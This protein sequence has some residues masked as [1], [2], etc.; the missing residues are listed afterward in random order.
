M[1]KAILEKDV[2]VLRGLIAGLESELSTMQERTKEREERV[3]SIYSSLEAISLKAEILQEINEMLGLDLDIDDLLSLIMDSVLR[4]MRTD[5]GSILLLDKS[6]TKLIFKVAKGPMADEVKKFDVP[7]GE[8]IAGWVAKEGQPLIVPNP[9]EDKRFKRDIAEEIGYL[10][11]NLLCVPL[12]A[13]RKVIGVIEVINTLGKEAFTKDDE[14]LLVSI[15]NQV[16]VLI[17]NAS[18]FHDLVRKVSEKTVLTEVARTVN[19]SLNIDRVLEISMKL[20]SQLMRSEASS[21]MLL[22][23]SKNELIFKVALGKKGESVKEIRI[24]L[25]V[26]IA[27][28]VAEKGEPLIVPDCSKDPMFFKDAD[29]KSGFKTRSILCVP[30]R[31]KDRTIGVAE[32]INKIG[33]TFVDEDI[34]LFEAIALQIAIALENASLYKDLEDLFISTVTSLAATI[35]AK[36]PYTHGHSQ[37]VCEYSFAIGKEMGLLEDEIKEL[38]LS[39]LLHDIGKIGI[40]EKILRK[41]AK[42][43]DDEFLEIKKHPGTGANII[44]HIKK[45]KDIC[46]SIRHHHERF[47]GGGYP[48]GLKGENIPLF[49]RII[50]VADT[51]DAMTSDRPYR[52]GLEPEVALA[53]IERCKGSQ[54]DEKCA[55]SFI[56]AYKEGKIKKKDDLE[57]AFSPLTS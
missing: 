26:G 38:K 52:K 31:I 50:A 3:R 1:N 44:D 25:G 41:P 15:A 7:L 54:F 11:Y 53:E 2:R 4:F 9:L 5:A 12:K 51:Y 10:P 57:L 46:P 43:T 8:G 28:Y 29:E 14:E 30:L 20:V 36:D 16:G 22:D 40:D 21:L 42:L 55:D 34:E 45:L 39:A 13:K 19:S 47:S 48:D 27:G 33:G 17:E 37:R 24:P 32:A 56:L 35:D 49:S 23:S 6:G 18:L